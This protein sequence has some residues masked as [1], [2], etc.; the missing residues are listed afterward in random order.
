[1]NKVLVT[2]GSGYIGSHVVLSL[3]ESDYE[4]VILD[5]LS[6]SNKI[7]LERVSDI[8]GVKPKFYEGDITDSKFLNFVFSQES[9]ESVIHL[10]GLKSVSESVEEP[11]KYY[12]NNVYGS[13]QLFM[14]MKSFDIKKVV[15]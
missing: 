9:I 6:N 14:A 12:K 10:A 11:L 4:V 15:F 8:C 13:L 2:G 7:S 1:M 3:I 5:N